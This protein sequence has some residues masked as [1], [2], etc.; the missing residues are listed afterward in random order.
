[1]LFDFNIHKNIS[2]SNFM[3]KTS[4][5]ELQILNTVTGLPSLHLSP[6]IFFSLQVKG[7]SILFIQLCSM[8]LFVKI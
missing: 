2:V 6:N 1:M 3:F 4:V 7:G 8:R 5:R